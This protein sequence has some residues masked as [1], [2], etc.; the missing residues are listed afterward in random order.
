MIQFAIQG[1]TS[2]SIKPLYLTIYF[3]LFLSFVSIIFYAIYLFYSIYHNIAISGWASLIST[4]VFFG[5][6]NLTV[7]GIIGIYIGKL[8]IQSKNRPNYIIKNTNLTL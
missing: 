2:F 4:V 8:F 1:I 3:G 6:L 5:G 7:L